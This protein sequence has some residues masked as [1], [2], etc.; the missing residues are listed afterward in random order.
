[1]ENNI[2][3]KKSSVV[4]KTTNTKPNPTSRTQ[5]SAVAKDGSNIKKD[6]FKRPNKFANSNSRYS[7]RPAKEKIFEEK[8]VSVSRVTKVTKGGRQFRFAAIVIIGDKKG[9]VGLGSGKANEVPDAIKKA[10]KF[11]EKNLIRVKIVNTT[12]PHEVF[13]RYAGGRVLLKPAKPG[14][15]IIA[16]GP[17]R[18]MMELS[19]IKDIYSKSLGSNSPINM[20]RATINA[21]EQIRTAEEIAFL[22]AK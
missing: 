18:A 2:E 7:K 16:G 21:L 22:R 8:V 6:G 9:R 5:S 1:M 3:N 12:I 19:G 10:I 20:I 11:A 4:S 17:V 15:G 13:G 14:K